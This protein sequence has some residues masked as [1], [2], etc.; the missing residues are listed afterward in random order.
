[1]SLRINIYHTTITNFQR[2]FGLQT[3]TLLGYSLEL[4]TQETETSN[5]FSTVLWVPGLALSRN[6]NF[7]YC[8]IF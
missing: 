4:G 8:N 6:S 7:R 3:E 5:F 2:S 1:M